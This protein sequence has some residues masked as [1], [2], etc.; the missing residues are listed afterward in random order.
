MLNAYTEFE[1]DDTTGE[2]LTIHDRLD[3][4]YNRILK[5]QVLF[6]FSAYFIM[7]VFILKGRNSTLYLSYD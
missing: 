6:Y 5:L 2:A 3:I 4:H 1:I 7:N